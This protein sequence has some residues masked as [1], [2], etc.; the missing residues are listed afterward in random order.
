MTYSTC[1][2][3]AQS[4]DAAK[5]KM[6]GWLLCAYQTTGQYHS[7]VAPCRFNPSRWQ[8]KPEKMK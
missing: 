3:C 2:T 1:S 7:P 8:P 4:A 5:D 6:P